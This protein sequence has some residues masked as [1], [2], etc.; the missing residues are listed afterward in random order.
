MYDYS[1]RELFLNGF[2]KL[3]E[4]FFVLERITEEFL[5]DLHSHFLE[6]NVEPHMFCSQWFLTL[7]TAKFPL[8]LVYRIMDLYLSEVW[9]HFVKGRI[10]GGDA[11]RCAPPLG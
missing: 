8:S 6:N 10:L 4:R 2:E 5:P 7:F 3:N 9:S 11:G 1:H